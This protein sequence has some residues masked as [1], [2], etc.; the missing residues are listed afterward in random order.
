M[1]SEPSEQHEGLDHV[2]QKW[3]IR[4]GAVERA[5]FR[6]CA[7][8]RKFHLELGGAA[9]AVTTLLGVSTQLPQDRW[10]L[11]KIF[12]ILLTVVAPVLTGLVSFL[13]FDEKSTLHHNAAGK[14]AAMK[15][16]LQLMHVEGGSAQYDMNK[17]R[18][19]LFQLCEK[20][21]TLTNQAPALYEKDAEQ[22]NKEVDG[23]EKTRR[24]SDKDLFVY[25]AENGENI[26]PQIIQPT[27]N[28]RPVL[29]SPG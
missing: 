24:L 16:K 21:D 19:D 11:C 5:H 28:A 22:L 26:A 20:W 6:R 29:V 1:T 17:A 10:N 15:R 23:N 9:V 8:F 4:A 25:P 12:T 18:R 7:L 3:E 2:I 14:F 27:G 13:R